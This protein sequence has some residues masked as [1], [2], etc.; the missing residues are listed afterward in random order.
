MLWG[1]IIHPMCTMDEEMIKG[2]ILINKNWRKV[3]I[4]KKN[5]EIKV[6]KKLWIFI[7]MKIGIIFCQVINKIFILHVAI[8][9]ILSIHVWK[10]GKDIFINNPINKIKFVSVIVGS[11]I[12]LWFI[13][14]DIIIDNEEIV[15]IMKKFMGMCE[16]AFLIRTNK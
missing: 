2:L 1:I 13:I 9:D 15:C 16:V 3:P 7:K 8:L 11:C 5:I 6:N 12:V 10:G 4:I 14:M